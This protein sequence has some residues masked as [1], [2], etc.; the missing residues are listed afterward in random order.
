MAGWT[1][2][3]NLLSEEIIQKRDEGCDVSGFDAMLN[4]AGED[5]NALMNVYSKLLE[6]KPSPD[7]RY[8]EPDDYDEI[9]ALSEGSDSRV[10]LDYGSDEV[11]DKFYGAWLGRCAGCALGKPFEKY[12]YCC[13]ANGRSGASYVKEWYTGAGEWP[14]KG[15][16]PSHSKAE[17]EP[18]KLSVQCY[19]SL[20]ENIKFMETDDDIRYMII[21]LLVC[22][23]KGC[24]FNQWD[25]GKFWHSYLTYSE[26]CTAETQAYLNF[27]HVT[28]HTNGSC[29]ESREKYNEAIKYVREYLN[30]YREW[31][32]AQIRIDIYAYAA[33]G[34]PA[35]AAKMAY[36]D[37][38]FS[39]VKNGIYGAMYTAAV[40]ASAF[41]E[42]NPMKCVKAGLAQIPKTSRLYE[43]IT[44]TIE[45][46]KKYSAIEDIQE[47]IWQ[48][49]GKY[50]WIH[51]IPN[52]AM[53]TAAFLYSDGDFEKG[54]SAAVSGGLDTDCNGATVGSMV[55]A[56]NG[57][58]AIPERWKKPLNDT[59]YSFV[60]GFHPIAISECAERTLRAAEKIAE[61]N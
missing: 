47:A 16:V 6:L 10:R 18:S 49:F 38:S 51:T 48:K 41:T 52:A 2:L 34:N 36:L 43:A 42:K 26:V 28:S 33:A 13:G 44:D 5:E 23:A 7:F 9:K 59:M 45:I 11:K 21:A 15:Y 3:H 58:A 31:I 53:C 54:I 24:D 27:A 40:I 37:S 29:P 32:G 57:A 56:L 55:G 46:T 35:L 19:P 8:K 12:P 22:E 39:H 14:I 25:V 50:N 1:G 4:D 60:P 61:N 17:E 20:R 30:P